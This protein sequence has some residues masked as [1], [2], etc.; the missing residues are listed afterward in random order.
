MSRRPQDADARARD[1][2]RRLAGGLPAARLPGRG[3]ARAGADDP[4]G[5]CAGS[6]RPIG[7]SIEEFLDHLETHAVA[8]AAGGLRR[9]LRQP[10]AVQPVP[11]LLRPRGH[12]QARD[13][14]AAVQ[15]D[16]PGLRVRARRRRAPR[17][18]LRRA[19]VRRDDRPSAGSSADA[20]PPCG[21]RA[22][23][24]LAARPG[25]AVVPG[26][27]RGR[28]RRCPPLRGDE[29]DA[30]RRL[31]AEGPPEE[32]VGLAPF[33]TPEFSPS[34]AADAAERDAADADL[35]GSRADERVP[36]RHRP[37]PL[38]DDV[39]GRALVALPLRQV[40]VDHAFLPALRE[41]AAAHRQPAVPLR[42]ARGRRRPRHRPAGARSR[43]RTR[44]GSAST[45][46]TWWPSPVG[47][48]PE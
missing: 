27:R 13:G 3:T 36:L 6:R 31:A 30:V 2:R 1:A 15:A 43:G 22:A 4:G 14:A 38:P 18:P 11:D 26:G 35:P 16:L 37:L 47:S 12:P 10:P 17:P 48:W 42:D 5:R 44:S 25:L 33:A 32:E 28:A 34:A 8:G 45:P 9:D 20:R 41:P 19:R 23:A 46:T 24:A 7:S 39:R 21:T 29:R 40:R